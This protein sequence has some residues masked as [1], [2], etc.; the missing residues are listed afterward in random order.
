MLRLLPAANSFKRDK[1]RVKIFT[2]ILTNDES[3]E[4]LVRKDLERIFGPIDSIL[5][6]TE[7]KH[8]K[9]YEEELGEGLRRSFFAFKKL[10]AV[11]DAYRAKITSGKV[12][13]KYRHKGK[14]RA[15]ID[16]G[17]ITPAKLVLFSTKDYSH[18]IFIARRI[19]AEVT[20]K[21]ENHSY[22]PF[23]WTYPDFKSKE[24]I[25]Y[26]NDIRKIYLSQLK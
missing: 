2:G 9:Y 20:L 23:P 5:S 1:N 26:F 19:Y 21:Y 22:C 7:F 15:N 18:R 16:P 10:A 11:K 3:I 4:N 12:E 17:Y 8:T 24:Y 6:G 14:R 25:E 13:D